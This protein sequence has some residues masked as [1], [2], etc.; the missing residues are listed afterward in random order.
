MDANVLGDFQICISVLSSCFYQQT[1]RCTLGD[2]LCVT[3]SN[4]YKLNLEN[5]QNVVDTL[6]LQP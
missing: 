6:F 3:F 4:V 5:N 2:P 1:D